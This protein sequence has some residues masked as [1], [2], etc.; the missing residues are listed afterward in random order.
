M[1]KKLQEK[2]ISLQEDIAKTVSR[3]TKMLQSHEY[4]AHL[5]II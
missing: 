3:T 1:N 5:L 2:L 4:S